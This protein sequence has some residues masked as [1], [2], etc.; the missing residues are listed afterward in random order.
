[1]NDAN[2]ELPI[3]V[4]MDV[5]ENSNV[6]EL[7]VDKLLNEFELTVDKLLNEFEL[8]VD[9]DIIVKVANADDYEGEYVIIPLAYDQQVL[10]TKDKFCKENIIVKE[11]PLWE[12]SN[13]SGGNT[14]YIAERL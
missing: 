11:V 2:I 1:M 7:T 3:I 14:V 4:N 12:T 5:I 9:S 6:Y 10:D 8:I 13:L